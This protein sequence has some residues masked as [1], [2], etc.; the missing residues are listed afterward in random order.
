MTGVA[1][2]AVRLADTILK[3]GRIHSFSAR[4]SAAAAMLSSA[5]RA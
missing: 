2:H 1:G 5:S 4:G 3:V